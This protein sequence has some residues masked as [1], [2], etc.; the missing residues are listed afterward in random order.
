ML[1]FLSD[2]DFNR[3]IVR[4]LRRRL[5]ALDIVRVQDRWFNHQTGRGSFRMGG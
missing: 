1:L 3:R 2:E 4:G 5:P